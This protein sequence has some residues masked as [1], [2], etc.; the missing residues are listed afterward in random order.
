[1][2]QRRYAALHRAAIRKRLAVEYR[3]QRHLAAVILREQQMARAAIA[4]VAASRGQDLAAGVVVLAAQQRALAMAGS[5]AHE[6]GAVRQE[7]RE[8]AQR[9]AQTEIALSLEVLKKDG[10]AVPDASRAKGWG[11]AGAGRVATDGVKARLLGEAVAGDWLRATLAEVINWERTGIVPQD[12]AQWIR[13]NK[14]RVEARA[15]LIGTTEVFDAFEDELE[16]EIHQF[17]TEEAKEEEWSHNIYRVWS[18]VMDKGTCE[19]CWRMDGQI[20]P[21]TQGFTQSPPLH[22]RCRCFVMTLAVPDAVRKKLP[23]MARDYRLLKEDFAEHPDEHYPVKQFIKDA[24]RTNSPQTVAA[25]LRERER[26]HLA[27]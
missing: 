14:A 20:R 18:A 15:R 2:V 7:A 3:A 16:R 5:I 27:H 6:V 26:R 8:M 24:L 13:Q 12:L 25:K 9:L 22:P 10:H 1:M 23:G 4:G 17:F 11:L 19:A 21:I